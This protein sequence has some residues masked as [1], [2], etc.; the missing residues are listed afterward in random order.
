MAEVFV[1]HSLNAKKGVKFNF[2]FK[3]YTLKNKD[4]EGDAKWVLEVGTT[5][6]AA[7]GG[8]IPTKIVYGITEKTL[9]AEIE[10][11]IASLCKYI[12]WTEFEQDKYAPE[13]VDIT[14]TGVGVLPNSLISFK[15]KDSLPS[16]GIDL[17]SMKVTLNNGTVDFDITD[18]ISISG[19]PYEY[20]ISW[21]NP[22]N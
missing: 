5:Y 20:L 7:N 13:V 9:D 19:D 18:Q 12:D 1:R 8:K 22:F 4:A 14:P 15:I 10:K 16:S 6:P 11:A 2:T 17:S 21:K 3:Q